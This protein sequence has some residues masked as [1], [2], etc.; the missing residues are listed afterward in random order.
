MYPI[1]PNHCAAIAEARRLRDE[2][3]ELRS[4]L[5]LIRS[6]TAAVRQSLR[7]TRDQMLADRQRLQSLVVLESKG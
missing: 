2:A 4:W 5:D 6:E 7:E 3:A 1:L